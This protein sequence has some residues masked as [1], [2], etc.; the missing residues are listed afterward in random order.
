MKACGKTELPIRLVAVIGGECVGTVALVENDLRCRPYTPW[1]ASL[2][3][4]PAHRGQKIGEGLVESVKAL[5]KDKGYRELY[6]RTEHA[7]GYYV[8]LGWEFVE[9]CEDDYGLKPDV[10]KIG[11]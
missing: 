5:A 2:I 6:L 4:A 9:T 3:V 8:K 11:L 1:L 10:F 7:S